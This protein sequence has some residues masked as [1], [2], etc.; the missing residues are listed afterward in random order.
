MIHRASD[1]NTS[2]TKLGSK[3]SS[4]PTLRAYNSVAKAKFKLEALRA[5]APTIYPCSFRTLAPTPRTPSVT[6][7]APSR[8][9]YE[10]KTRVSTKFRRHIYSSHQLN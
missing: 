8:A 9:N 1:S 2:G 4:I 5:N 3:A 10:L 6:S 7:N